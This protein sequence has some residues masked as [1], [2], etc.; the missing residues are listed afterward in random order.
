MALTPDFAARIVHSDA[1]ITDAVAFHAALRD[2]EASEVGVLYPSI[3]SYRQVELGGG[4]VFP[5]NSAVRSRTSL[6][7]NQHYLVNNTNADFRPASE[8][9][10]LEEFIAAYP[11]TKVNLANGRGTRTLGYGATT[12]R[13]QRFA[14][15]GVSSA[16]AG[17]VQYYDCALDATETNVSDC[18]ATGTG[19]YTISTVSGSPAS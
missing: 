18:A 4:A 16:V 11:A 9:T 13:T 19:T 1:S 15:T 7:L 8:A 2:I 5:A 3:H 17:T 6:M 14:F 10:T 12:S